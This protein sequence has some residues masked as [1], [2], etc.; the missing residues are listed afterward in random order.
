MLDVPLALAGIL[1]LDVLCSPA[2][3]D[4][5]PLLWVL[6]LPA[7]GESGDPLTIVFSVA[8]KTCG[9][10]LRIEMFGA[11]TTIAVGYLVRVAFAV[12]SIRFV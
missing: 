10:L 2:L 5:A 9:L 4:V 3:E 11:P 12:A 6:F 1:P 8:S 7:S